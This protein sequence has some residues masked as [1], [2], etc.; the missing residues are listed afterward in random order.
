MNEWLSGFLATATDYGNEV[1]QI[2]K[3]VTGTTAPQTTVA[4][5]TTPR[6]TASTQALW[7]R[8]GMYGGAALAVVVVL[9][10]V[11]KRK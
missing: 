6:A 11:F 3:Q 9:F 10:F 8:W 5:P 7:A 4:S 2:Y 1:G